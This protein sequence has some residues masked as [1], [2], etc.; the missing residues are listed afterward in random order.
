[1]T[2]IDTKSSISIKEFAKTIDLKDIHTEFHII[3]KINK[4][5][6]SQAYSTLLLHKILV[7]KEY[8]KDIDKTKENVLGKKPIITYSTDG[9]QERKLRETFISAL[10]N[11]ADALECIN[12]SNRFNQYNSIIKSLKYDDM[13]ELWKM[14]L[15]VKC[16]TTKIIENPD[17]QNLIKAFKT[18]ETGDLF[19][20]INKINDTILRLYLMGNTNKSFIYY[21]T[22]LMTCSKEDDIF[23][24]NKQK[25]KYE[26]H[27]YNV[28][29]DK[30]YKKNKL[31]NH[32][33]EDEEKRFYLYLLKE[34]NNICEAFPT[35]F[36]GEINVNWWGQ[37]G[38]RSKSLKQSKSFVNNY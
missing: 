31:N 3:K 21:R 8:S 36:Q 20:D 4:Q 26:F 9:H 30:F 18:Y 27:K 28:W 24:P 38:Y 13:L 10:I 11:R 1:M 2:S 19:T 17:Q 15:K 22:Y 32:F 12:F 35:Y 34:T 23:L 5:N 16:Y 37:D 6:F 33:L 25:A 29:L 7:F 14:Y